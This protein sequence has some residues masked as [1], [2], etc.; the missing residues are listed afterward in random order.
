MVHDA[1]KDAIEKYTRK[2]LTKR[3]SELLNELA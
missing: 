1:D 3:L 2:N